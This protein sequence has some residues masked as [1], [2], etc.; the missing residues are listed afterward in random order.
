MAKDIQDF[1]V[2]APDSACKVTLDDFTTAKPMLVM[3]WAA[4]WQDKA[5]QNQIFRLRKGC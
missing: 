2:D 5:G 4:K 3:V 1:A